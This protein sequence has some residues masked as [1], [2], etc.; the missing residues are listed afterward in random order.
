MSQG[1]QLGKVPFVRSSDTDGN[2]HEQPSVGVYHPATGKLRQRLLGRLRDAQ[3]TDEALISIVTCTYNRLPYVRECL[4]SI[5]DHT[6]GPLELFIYDNASSDETRDYLKELDRRNLDGVHVTLLSENIGKGKAMNLGLERARGGT[7]ITIDSDIRVPYGWA[8]QLAA[9]ARSSDRVGW[10]GPW[11]EVKGSPICDYPDSEYGTRVGGHT[12]VCHPAVAGGVVCMTR[13]S[14]EKL[15]PYHE[16]GVYGGVDGEYAGR[17]RRMGYLVGYTKEVVVEHLEGR[18]LPEYQEYRRWKIAL[19]Q[20]M[21]QESIAEV[22]P[23]TGFWDKEPC[24]R[25]EAGK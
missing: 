19:Q 10:V 12:L 3:R 13:R 14:Y 22:V 4:E 20:R 1:W 8:Q 15:G 7:L 9:V 23:Q 21:H 6:T 5:V 2:V 24:P 11:Y 18:G 25:P 17:A 16:L